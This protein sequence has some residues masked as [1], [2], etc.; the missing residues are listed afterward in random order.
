MSIQRYD[1][2]HNFWPAESGWWVSYDDHIAEMRSVEAAAIALGFKAGVAYQREE[3]S[4]RKLSDAL[5]GES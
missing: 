3:D 2:P 5:R 4:L 1:T